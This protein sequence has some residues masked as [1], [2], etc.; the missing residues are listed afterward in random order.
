MNNIIYKI[1]CNDCPANYIGE[2][3]RSFETRAKEHKRAIRNNDVEKN[4]MVEHCWKND[5]S[6]NWDEQK[7]IDFE[8][9]LISRKIKESIHSI[10]DRNHINSISYTLPDIWIPCLKNKPETQRTESTS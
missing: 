2:S 3:K 5:H 6:M 1:A 8:Q 4:E 7:I 10:K 9:N